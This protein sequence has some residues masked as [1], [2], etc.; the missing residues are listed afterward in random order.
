[1]DELVLDDA[2]DEAFWQQLMRR[3]AGQQ[4][5]LWLSP[6]DLRH[7][8]VLVSAGS[9]VKG[10][11]LSSSLNAGPR[12][13]LAAN[14]N[15]RVRLVYP[16]DVP[17]ERAARLEVVRRWLRSN[18]VAPGDEK[19]QMNAYLAATVT[20]M[21]V[22]HSRDTYSREFLIERMEHRLG[23]SLELSIYPQLSLGP[24]QRYASKGSYVVAVGG[25]DDR[26][27]KPLSDWIVP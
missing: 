24:G 26:Q 4:W 20:G 2:P 22:T 12:A 21:L 5:V 8:Q 11:Y 14:G 17:A 15:G 25:P 23:T 6:G 13:G 7:A 3:K 18:N 9:P 19:V 16:Q 27:L 1:V 10:V